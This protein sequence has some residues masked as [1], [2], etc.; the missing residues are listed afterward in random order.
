MAV[1]IMVPLDGS[2]FGEQAL[3]A[4]L[5][6]ARRRNATIHLVRV[7]WIPVVNA[8]AGLSAYY[9]M[10]GDDNSVAEIRE[11][12]DGVQAM[13]EAQAVSAESYSIGG[14]VGPALASYVKAYG[15]DLIVMTTHGRGG[16]SRAWLGSVADRL[17]RSVHVPVLMLRPHGSSVTS[18]HP[19]PTH[20]LI[21]LD[22]SD[23][24]ETIIEPAIALATATHARFTLMQVVPPPLSGSAQVVQNSV[25]DMA[26]VRAE[27]TR[28]LTG[29]AMRLRARGYEADIR[30]IVQTQSALGIIE[31]ALA[32]NCDMIAMAT[33]G[34]SGWSRIALGSV[35]DKVMRTSSAPLLTL[36]AGA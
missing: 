20:I 29:W 27:A 31:E 8:A 15:I 9:P 2:G 25:F 16:L 14:P 3:P 32:S 12:L 35:T 18:A 13:C 24:S 5:D 7:H 34:R 36:S 10:N 6:L 28:Y 11:Y 33:H 4:A 22:G 1:K 30:V 17:V 26:E 21:P 23:L 19:A